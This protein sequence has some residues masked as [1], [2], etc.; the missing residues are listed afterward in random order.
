MLASRRFASSELIS[1]RG[2]RE[3]VR[4]FCFGERGRFLHGMFYYRCEI[5]VNII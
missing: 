3:E 4:P 1:A 5:R 2:Y